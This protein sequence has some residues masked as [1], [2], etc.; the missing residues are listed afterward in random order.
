MVSFDKH[1]PANSHNVQ[2]VPISVR[3]LLG[4]VDLVPPLVCMS[5]REVVMLF[6][7]SPGLLRDFLRPVV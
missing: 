4:T 6:F 2:I 7:W 5:S 3:G 1:I